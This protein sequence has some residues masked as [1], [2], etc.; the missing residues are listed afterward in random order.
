MASDG[1]ADD[2]S[3]YDEETRSL[4]ALLNGVSSVA[5]DRQHK[6]ETDA[7]EM[8]NEIDRLQKQLN[9]HKDS[10]MSTETKTDTA[11]TSDRLKDSLKAGATQA[12]T[13]EA[14]E[15]L[16][17]VF[18]RL[19]DGAVPEFFDTPLGKELAKGFIAAAV[20]AAIDHIPMTASRATV[21]RC[22]E[23]QVQ[24]TAMRVLQPHMAKLTEAAALLVGSDIED[25][26]CEAAKRG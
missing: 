17:V 6:A 10:A 4:V 18:H 16:L 5:K 1:Y 7:Q 2:G 22:A 9:H 26:M 12:A 25:T 20:I 14:S 3:E 23:L 24:T 13:D 21:L 11:K 8:K 19:F 15:M